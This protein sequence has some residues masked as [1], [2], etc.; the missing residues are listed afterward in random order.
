[1]Y[2]ETPEI[3]N[4]SATYKKWLDDFEEKTVK[5][6][7]DRFDPKRKGMGKALDSNMYINYRYFINSNLIK[8]IKTVLEFYDKLV[9]DGDKNRIDRLKSNLKLLTG[10]VYL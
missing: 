1:M 7:R 5:D 4:N 10:N 2:E 6:Y 9:K 8:D 3:F